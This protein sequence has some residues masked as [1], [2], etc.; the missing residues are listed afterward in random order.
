MWAGVG[1]IIVVIIGIVLALTLRSG[2]D[3]DASTSGVAQ[4]GD[5]DPVT[6]ATVRI[7][8]TLEPTNLDIRTTSGVALDQILIDNVYE[9]IVS[10]ASDGSIVPSLASSWTVSEDALTYTFTLQPGVTFSNGDALT[11]RTAAD[12]INQAIQTQAV[13]AVSLGDVKSVDAPDDT[14]LIVTLNTPN[15]NLLW[16][17]AGRPGLVLDPSATNDLKSS[18][19][20]SGPYLLSDWKQGDSITLTRNDSYWGEPAKVKSVVLRY[21]TDNNAAVNALNSGDLDILA[22]INADLQTQVADSTTQLVEGDASDK[23]VL[24]F[25]NASGPL[26]DV[27]VRQAIRYAIDHP[28]LVQ[29]RGGVDGLLGGPITPGDPGYRDLTALFPHDV[30]KAKQLLVDAGYADGLTLTLTTP[31]I[32]GTTFSDLLTSQLSEV[33]ITLQTNSVDFS[34]W[35][36]D[37][38][39]NKNY[40]LSIV[41]HAESHDFASWANPDYYFGYNNPQVQDLYS[42]ASI[43]TTGEEQ[44]SLLAEA[45]QVVSQDAAADWLTN[46]RT[47]IAIRS[48]ISG[49]PTDRINSRLDLTSLSVERG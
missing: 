7:G 34:T 21:I 17:L 30:D 10:R 12:S 1:L 9:G 44:D 20:G 28:A 38:Y 25:N 19:V 41:D 37:V 31:N 5:T 6:D 29:A 40:E 43:A 11:A 13:D 35:L 33:G 4:S 46:F 18:A 48:G 45:A 23:F 47:V 42:R 27:R 24:A 39:T 8:L 26:T 3:A 32:Y 36:T 14:V 2:S 22:P 49:V 15:P 16:A